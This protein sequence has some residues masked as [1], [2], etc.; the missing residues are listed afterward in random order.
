MRA[1]FARLAPVSDR[2]AAGGPRERA[3]ARLVCQVR[4]GPLALSASLPE[5]AASTERRGPRAG[6][7]ASSVQLAAGDRRGAPQEPLG[8]M[9]VPLERTELR[10]LAERCGSWAPRARVRP[11][12][13]EAEGR[14]PKQGVPALGPTGHRRPVFRGRAQSAV[15]RRI[16]S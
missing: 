5:W 11:G 14:Q 15:A 13:A 12:R 3:R 16:D 4:P 8:S 1:A 10:E 9:R 7:A 6:R 2:R